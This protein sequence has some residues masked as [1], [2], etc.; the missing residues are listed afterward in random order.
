VGADC[1]GNT[2]GGEREREEIEVDE[3]AENIPLLIAVTR[4]AKV[5]SL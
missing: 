5:K 4:R 1:H 3:A 2:E